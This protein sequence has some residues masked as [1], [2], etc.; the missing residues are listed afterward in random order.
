MS[1]GVKILCD[2]CG[3]LIM[4]S[5]ESATFMA[6]I[7]G[8]VLNE[9]DACREKR[10]V[11][12]LA[13]VKKREKAEAKQLVAFKRWLKKHGMTEKQF[14]KFLDTRVPREYLDSDDD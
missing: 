3:G 12:N 13:E 8:F 6:T 7:S 14:G 5:H 2:S 10:E 11:R 1:P 4:I 9:C